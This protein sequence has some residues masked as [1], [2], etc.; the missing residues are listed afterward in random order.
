MCSAYWERLTFALP[1]VEGSEHA[2]RRCIDTALPSPDDISRFADAPVVVATEY[3]LQPR[4][5]VVLT[6]KLPRPT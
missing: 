5:L 2:W 4:S 1:E 3:T 6:A